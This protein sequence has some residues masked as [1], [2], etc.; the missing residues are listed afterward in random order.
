MLHTNI[1]CSIYFF[2][3]LC[4][5]K[6][7]MLPLNILCVSVTVQ[8]CVLYTIRPWWVL[9]I[10]ITVRGKVRCAIVQS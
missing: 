4:G 8:K 3:I 1:F 5:V 10:I 6:S 9:V 2:I 7:I